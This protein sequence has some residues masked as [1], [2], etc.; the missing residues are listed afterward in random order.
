[1]N[2]G[3][4]KFFNLK[5]IVIEVLATKKFKKLKMTVRVDI[6]RRIFEKIATF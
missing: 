6:L 4:F 1:M 5:K 2:V 3:E